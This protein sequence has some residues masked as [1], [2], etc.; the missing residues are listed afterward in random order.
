MCFW[1]KKKIRISTNRCER[2]IWFSIRLNSA[3]L[4]FF[5]LS[6]ALGWWQTSMCKLDGCVYNW[7]YLVKSL[8]YYYYLLFVSRGESKIKR[9]FYLW[10][11]QSAHLI[12]FSIEYSW[13]IPQQEKKGT[14]RTSIRLNEISKYDKTFCFAVFHHWI[15]SIN[16]FFLI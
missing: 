5:S 7:P 14:P 15:N 16:H 13:H 8:N 3:S 4:W 11:I 12:F 1:V 10:P 6:S 9:F 2:F